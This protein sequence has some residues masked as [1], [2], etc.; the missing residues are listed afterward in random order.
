M[1]KA[2]V[3]LPGEIT[4]DELKRMLLGKQLFLRGGYLDNNLNFNER[5]M[6]IGHSQQ[7]SYTLNEIQIERVRLT[8]HKVEMEGT[9]YGLHFLGA[10]AY[11][12][13]A[14]AV[15][16]IRITPKKKVVRITIDLS[17]IHI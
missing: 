13:P 8:K 7:G 17:L 6:L 5:G 11:E 4:E 9:R 10:L 12:D 14:T 2:A 3:P 1:G 16:P 15:D